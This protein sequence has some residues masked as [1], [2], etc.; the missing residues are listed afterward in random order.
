MVGFVLAVTLFSAYQFP[1]LSECGLVLMA[2]HRRKWM[3]VN[4]GTCEAYH[5]SCVQKLAK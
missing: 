3:A 1:F 5:L 4:V 2:L